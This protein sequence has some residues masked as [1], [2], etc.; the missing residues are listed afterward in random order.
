M[1]V[2]RWFEING[3]VVIA[4]RLEKGARLPPFLKCG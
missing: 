3:I 2:V 4:V 1:Q